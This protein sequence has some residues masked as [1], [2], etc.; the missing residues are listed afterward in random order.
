VGC[1][2]CLSFVLHR[3][4]FL[5]IVT[6]ISYNIMG[7]LCFYCGYFRDV[8]VEYM[9]CLPVILKLFVSVRMANESSISSGVIF[10]MKNWYEF[11]IF[12]M[13]II[14]YFYI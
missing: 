7:A 14:L 13:S 2:G 9:G 10:R 5:N 8:Y 3:L 1:T 12:N 11:E 4:L 6:F